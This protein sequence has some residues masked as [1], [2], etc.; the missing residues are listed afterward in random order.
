MAIRTSDPSTSNLGSCSFSQGQSLRVFS[1]DEP[2]VGF[3]LLL[4]GYRRI[5]QR[6]NA[7][8]SPWGVGDLPS[9]RD[10]HSSNIPR[11]GGSPSFSRIPKGASCVRPRYELD[12]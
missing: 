4:L 5:W 10:R 7:Q 8:E 9:L 6:R 2:A 1:L 12:E 3:R 11:I